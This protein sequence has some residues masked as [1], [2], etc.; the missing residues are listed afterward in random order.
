MMIFIREK[1]S[2]SFFTECPRGPS[3]TKSQEISGM[4]FLKSFLSRG[5]KTHYALID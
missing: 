3:E 2:K 4:A 5:Q 1:K